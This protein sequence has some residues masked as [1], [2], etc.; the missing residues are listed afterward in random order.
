MSALEEDTGGAGRESRS[1][2]SW[3]GQHG[4]SGPEL[5]PG[6]IFLSH[7]AAPQM[8]CKGQGGAGHVDFSNGIQS[9]RKIGKENQSHQGKGLEKA[10]SSSCSLCRPG[11]CFFIYTRWGSAPGAW[12]ESPSSQ[13]SS[14]LPSACIS[15]QSSDTV[16]SLPW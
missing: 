10:F 13:W 3:E 12:E 9:W 4:V 14:I 2:L 6:L 16:S 11:W 7:P 5:N 1:D 15:I 8:G